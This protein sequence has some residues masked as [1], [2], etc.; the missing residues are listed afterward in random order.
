M[1]VSGRKVKV[2][3][4]KDFKDVFRNP[5]VI[6]SCLIPVLFIALYKNITMGSM[7]IPT[8]YLMKIGI[9][10]NLGMTPIM[11]ISTMIA[12]E[13]EKNTMRTLILANV[14]GLEFFLSKMLVPL[15]FLLV[16]D[17]II[18]L[19]V[20]MS[21]KYIGWFMLFN[22]LGG[23]DM[24]MLGGVI[25]ILSRDQMTAGVYQVP[26]MLI[27]LLPS[28][29]GEMNKPLAKLAMLTPTESVSELFFASV[30]GELFAKNSAIALV[31]LLI[32]I[33]ISTMA[34][35]TIYKKKGAD[36]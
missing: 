32:W 12:E 22:L 19:I 3:Y 7:H 31:V 33:V 6:V 28:L 14:N 17:L 1:A 36:N 4:V 26:I 34:F 25:G 2:L 9:V 23:I 18:Y 15:T 35:V 13:K 20:G 11:I 5:S 16:S 21:V 29:L 27:L 30:H 8:E 10:F 24:I